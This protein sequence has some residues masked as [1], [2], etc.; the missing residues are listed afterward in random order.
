MHRGKF[1]QKTQT[2]AFLGMQEDSYAQSIKYVTVKLCNAPA[3]ARDGCARGG[4]DHADGTG[5]DDGALYGLDGPHLAPLP[6]VPP[7]LEASS[8]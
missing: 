3:Q 2:T 5:P 4:R 1:V 7:P 6:L 8:V